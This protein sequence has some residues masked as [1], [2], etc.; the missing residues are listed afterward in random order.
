MNPQNSHDAEIA[1]TGL[2]PWQD[3]VL[4]R[5]RKEVTLQSIICIWC[6]MD[7]MLITSASCLLAHLKTKILFMEIRAY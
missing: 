4:D 5:L 6:T 3:G 2:A 7:V 1:R